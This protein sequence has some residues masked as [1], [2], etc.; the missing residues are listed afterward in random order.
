MELNVL[1]VLLDL[2]ER[3][4]GNSL[5]G[6]NRVKPQLAYRSGC[7]GRRGIQVQRFRQMLL[8]EPTYAVR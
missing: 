8:R 6:R 4:F 1:H 5:R 2:G 7:G 3:R